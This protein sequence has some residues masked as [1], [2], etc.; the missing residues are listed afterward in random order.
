VPVIASEF[1]QTDGGNSYLTTFM[2]W[3]DAHGIGYAPW[4]WWVVDA[5]ESVSSSRYALITD[6][7]TFSPKAPSGT[8]FHDHLATL[9]APV[10]P[11][12][13][14]PPSRSGGGSPTPPT[15]PVPVVPGDGAG[16][17]T[18]VA[19]GAGSHAK[20]FVPAAAAAAPEHVILNKPAIGLWHEE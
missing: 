20:V 14:R 10:A 13:P 7:T 11:A 12:P 6:D 4:A 18:P 2:T 17:R 5:S 8:A 1:G 16:S 19:G 9:P 3:A 15:A